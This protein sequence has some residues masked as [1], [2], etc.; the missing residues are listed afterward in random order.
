MICKYDVD[1]VDDDDC[2][3]DDGSCGS[4]YLWLVMTTITINLGRIEGHIELVGAWVFSQYQWVR[5]KT[6]NKIIDASSSI[7]IFKII[8]LVFPVCCLELYALP[9]FTPS[10]IVS[11]LICI[12]KTTL[13]GPN[14]LKVFQVFPSRNE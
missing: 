8:I 12:A 2:D 11:E 13:I 1:D 3:Y 9:C 14:V 4:C 6:F 5:V 10:P 7:V